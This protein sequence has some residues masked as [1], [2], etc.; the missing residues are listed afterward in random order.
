MR[1]IDADKLKKCAIPCEIH[2]GALTDMCVPLYQIDNAPTVEINTND[3]EYKAYCKGLEDGKKI[4]RPQGKW[5]EQKN[6]SFCYECNQ[7][8]TENI[9][10]AYYCPYC[11]ADMRGDKN[12][13]ND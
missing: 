11:G 4:A 13:N 6:Y 5:I 1:L 8:G 3:I 12:A 10:K 7:C 9:H 2:N